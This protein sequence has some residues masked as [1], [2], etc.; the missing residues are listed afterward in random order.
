MA[1]PLP[2]IVGGGLHGFAVAALGRRL[3]G[4]AHLTDLPEPEGGGRAANLV[5]DPPYLVESGLLNEGR[6]GLGLR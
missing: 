2:Q 6:E 3:E 1:K 5:A 4:H